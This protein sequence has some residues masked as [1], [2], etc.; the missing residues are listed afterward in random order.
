MAGGKPGPRAV[1]FALL[2]L[3]SAAAWPAEGNH[4]P[5]C[6]TP[7][8]PQDL[9]A[10]RGPG[11]GEVSLD[12]DA[13]PDSPCVGVH[14]GDPLAV[15]PS[16]YKVY[17]GTQSGDLSFLT[18]STDTAYTDT[19]LPDGATRYY[20]VTAVLLNAQ[21]DEEGPPSNEASNTT[22]ELPGAPQGLVA[23]RG[24][25]RGE[26]SLSWQAP[27]D[28]GGVAIRHYV[29]YGGESA[30]GETFLVRLGDVTSHVDGGLPD[31]VRRHYRVSA[32][33]VVGEGPQSQ[34]ASAVTP[35]P[36]AAP[37]SLTAS[38]G[39]GAGEI[40]LDW[41][42][43][44]D[45]G[46]TAVVAYRV[47][48]G[49]A[50]G[51]LSF[52][53]EVGD[54][55]AYTDTDRPAGATFYYQVAARNAVGEG[56]RSLE[57]KGSAPVLPGPPLALSAKP[58]LSLAVRGLSVTFSGIRLDWQP[59]A[60]TGGDLVGYRIYRGAASGDLA[61]LAQVGDVTT[62]QDASAAILGRYYYQVS[63]VNAVG[64]GPPSPEA[65]GR[66][67]IAVPVLTPPC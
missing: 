53:V 5:V 54:V 25:G 9:E 36:P 62:Y 43:P 44:A 6:A 40:T 20:H 7:T 19:G 29:V 18:T 13:P 12:W 48:R 58:A 31:E 24:P 56:T 37:A 11:R 47:Y 4:I 23:S 65:C 15:P 63:A 49:E 51:A 61:L 21:P 26:I 16:Y 33:N 41:E 22:P 17:R 10:S 45:D 32:E 42:A 1:A 8:A 3:L 67:F 30:G 66:H 57:A 39:P 28:T 64:E 38:P 55:R 50:S 14:L 2:M 34:G 60:Y 35:G 27:G 59:P 46:G 52:L